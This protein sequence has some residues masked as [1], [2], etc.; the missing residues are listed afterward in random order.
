LETPRKGLSQE[1]RDLMGEKNRDKLEKDKRLTKLVLKTLLTT[2]TL[3]QAKARQIN[4]EKFENSH[5]LQL[6]LC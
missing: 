5:F 2:Q 6:N 3:H 4:M 1:S